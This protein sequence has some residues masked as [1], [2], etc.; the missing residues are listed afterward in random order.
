M[1]LFIAILLSEELLDSLDG[2]AQA[3]RRLA[4]RGNYTKRE[5]M[6]LTLSFLGEVSPDDLHKVISAVDSLQGT[7]FSLQ[8]GTAG[9]FRREDGDIWWVGVREN[10]DLRRLQH[11]LTDALRLRGLLPEERSFSPHLTIGREVVLSGGGQ[12]PLL[13]VGAARMTVSKIS[14]MRSERISGRLVYS[15]LH[16]K[17][18]TAQ[19]LCPTTQK[20]GN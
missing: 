11:Q 16:K 19:N 13:P 6:H 15:E 1:R 7:P 14:L 5:N 18:L 20:E 9:R 4:F 10:E 3:L 2:T 8:I 12:I 17:L